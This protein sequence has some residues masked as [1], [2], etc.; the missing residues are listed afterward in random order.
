MVYHLSETPLLSVSTNIDAVK[1]LLQ[2]EELGGSKSFHIYLATEDPD[3]EKQ[4][5]L[6]AK[7]LY[8]NVHSSGPTIASPGR[9]SMQ[10]IAMSIKGTAV[11]DS[12]SAP[13]VSLQ[14]NRYILG[15]GSNWSR[16]INE[17]RNN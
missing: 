16:L 14:A 5:S 1:S 10:P 12:L 8:W 15:A 9:V 11:L 13:L 17:L 2:Q 3:A 6:Q 7:E 4:L